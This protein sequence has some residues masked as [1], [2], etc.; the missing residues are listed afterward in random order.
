MPIKITREDTENCQI[1]IFEP[2]QD[3][4]PTIYDLK[5]LVYRLDLQRHFQLSD[6]ETKI[7]SFIISFDDISPRFYFGNEKLSKMFGK[8]TTT[9]SIAIS[10]LESKGLISCNRQIM[11]G[12]GEIRFIRLS[13]NLKQGFKKTVSEALRK[14]KENSNKINSNKIN[15]SKDIGDDSSPSKK[16]VESFGNQDINTSI[17]YL[18]EKLNSS[19]DGTEKE[20]RQYC[21]NLLRKLKKDYPEVEPVDSIKLL[22]DTAFQDKF[23][24][25]NSTGF[26][27]LFYNTQKIAQSF[28]KDYGIGS[29][30]SDIQ[31]I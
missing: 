23:H 4:E 26:K 9:V 31:I 22:I 20:N 19:L 1:A 27:Y 10:N 15:I 12:G 13:E 5:Y 6:T 11:A 16:V 7:I 17:N 18:K 29:N 8:S 14:P 3:E 24:S 28:K 21:Y 2:I 30:N 25:R